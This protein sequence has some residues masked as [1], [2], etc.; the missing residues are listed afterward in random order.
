MTGEEVEIA[1]GVFGAVRGAAQLSSR[2]MGSRS[3]MRLEKARTERAL[4]VIR[5]LPPGG[6][7]SETDADGRVWTVRIPGSPPP[8]L[9][10]LR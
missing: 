7:W 1:L 10:A 2:A 3:S 4:A 8:T 9:L 5:A 6:E